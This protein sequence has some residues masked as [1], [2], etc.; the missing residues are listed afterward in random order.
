MIGITLHNNL[1][2][3]ASSLKHAAMSFELP[4]SAGDDVLS[5]EELVDVEHDPG[6]VAEEEE[7][8]DAEQDGRQVHLA[9]LLLVVLLRP[10]VGHPAGENKVENCQVDLWWKQQVNWLWMVALV[11]TLSA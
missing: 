6:E 5:H 7:E 8:D 2:T 9:R 1:N 10:L 11:A 4:V 3:V